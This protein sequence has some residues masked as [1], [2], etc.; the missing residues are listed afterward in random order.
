MTE[1]NEG[2]APASHKRKTH[3]RMPEPTGAF[4]LPPAK[5]DY[6][7]EGGLRKVTPYQ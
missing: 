3:S 6:Y 7:E 2:P 1:F 5:P 4:A